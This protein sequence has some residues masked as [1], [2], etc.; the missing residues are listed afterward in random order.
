MRL[1]EATGSIDYWSPEGVGIWK[2][3]E[4]QCCLFAVLPQEE[5]ER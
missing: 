4:T 3:G 2:H 5:L 1:D